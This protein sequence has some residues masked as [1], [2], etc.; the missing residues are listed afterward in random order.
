MN[1]FSWSEFW[2][3]EFLSIVMHKELCRETC[4]AYNFV[5]IFGTTDWYHTTTQRFSV[6]CTP[7]SVLFSFIS[8]PSWVHNGQFMIPYSVNKWKFRAVQVTWYMG[9]VQQH[10]SAI[11]QWNKTTCLLPI[12]FKKDLCYAKRLQ[13]LN[14]CLIITIRYMF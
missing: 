12:K 6:E 4:V 7:L 3:I 5:F 9:M 13:A 2:K 11:N 14:V 10:D 1:N 8:C